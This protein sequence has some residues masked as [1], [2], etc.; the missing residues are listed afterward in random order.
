MNDKEIIH[1]LNSLLEHCEEFD[2]NATDIWKKD[3]IALKNAI[4]AIEERTDEFCSDG[5]LVINSSLAPYIKR[6]VVVNN[7]E[8]TTY[9]K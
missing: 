4:R 9:T 6:I 1:Q 8:S 2:N 3:I 7:G 5:T